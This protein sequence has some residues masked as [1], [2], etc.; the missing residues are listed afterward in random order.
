M[1]YTDQE[2]IEDY[3]DRD[4]TTAEEG[5][6]DLLIASIEAWINDQTGLVFGGSAVSSTRYYD[7]GSKI[8]DIDPVQNITKVCRVNND[9]T[10]DYE[11]ELNIDFEARPRNAT[12]KNWIEKRGGRFPK[13]VTNI[14]VTG[15][16]A[17]GI[18]VPDDISYLATYLAATQIESSESGNLKSETIEGY[19]RTFS[20]YKRDDAIVS[21]TLNKYTRNDTNY[22]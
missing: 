10:E 17:L 12:V 16:F 11:Y 4:L 19:S 15:Q 14:A 1:A 3:L 5:L 20:E 2:K 7:G 21:S 8:L 9:E 13:G 18:D 6:L 22:F